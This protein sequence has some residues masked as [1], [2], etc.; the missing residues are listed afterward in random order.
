MIDKVQGISDTESMSFKGGRALDPQIYLEALV[1]RYPALAGAREEIQRS[2]ELLHASLRQGGKVLLAGNGGSCADAEHIVGELMKGFVKRRP[3]SA[4][5]RKKLQ[6]AD[7][8]LGRALA[9]RLQVGLPAIALSNHAALNTAFSNDVD[10]AMTYAQQVNGYGRKGDVY[11]GI[12]TSG[13][14]LDV[15]YAAVVARAKGMKVIGLSGRDG[16]RLRQYCHSMICVPEQE[17]YKIQELHLPI[18]HTLGL[19]LAESLCP[20]QPQ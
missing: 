11:W 7:G 12:S 1:A 8:V 14:A 16:G 20:D 3:V 15:C 9:D 19:M 18:Y 4:D 13:N 10:G 17:T 5:L 6:A 2:Y